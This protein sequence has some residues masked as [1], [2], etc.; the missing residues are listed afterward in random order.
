[1]FLSTVFTLDNRAIINIMAY[2]PEY[3]TA[4]LSTT[5]VKVA[6]DSLFKMSTLLL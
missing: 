4:E 2:D 1:M 6:L 3:C 5:D